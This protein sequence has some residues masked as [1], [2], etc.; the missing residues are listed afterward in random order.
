[1]PCGNV[2]NARFKVYDRYRT[3]QAGASDPYSRIFA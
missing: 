2:A 1:M 3:K